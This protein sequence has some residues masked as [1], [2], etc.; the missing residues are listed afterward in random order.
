[1]FFLLLI[2]IFGLGFAYLAT[3]NTAGV[4]LY[5]GNYMWGGVPLYV[6]ALG[7]LLF[8]I[9]ISWVFS[10]FDWAAS[11]LTLHGKESTIKKAAQ[12]VDALQQKIHELELENARLCAKDK[13]IRHDI[14][15]AEE[16][17]PGNFLHRLR[18]GFSA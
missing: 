15:A 11:S 6:I 17:K 16:E 9:F 14:D 13:D 1:M 2:G 10:L 4:V 7:S 3:Q 12:E 8:G 18:H 5:V